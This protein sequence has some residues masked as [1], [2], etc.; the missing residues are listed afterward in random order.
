MTPSPVATGAAP[1]AAVDLPSDADAGLRLTA[2]LFEQLFKRRPTLLTMGAGGLTLFGRPGDRFAL[3]IPVKWGATVAAGSRDDGMVDLRS[4][5][6][7]GNELIRPVGALGDLPDWAVRPLAVVASAVAAGQP[8][9]GMSLLVGTALPESAG[10]QSDVALTSVLASA[11]AGLFGAELSL[12]RRAGLGDLPAQLAALSCPDDT[13]ML[14]DTREMTAEMV[15]FDLNGAG[16]RLMLIDLG[17]PVASVASGPAELALAAAD[18]LR[19]GNLM[20]LGPCSRRPPT[21]RPTR[22]GSR[23]QWRAPPPPPAPWASAPC[24]AGA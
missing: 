22:M 10:M 23:P 16:L 19:S 7:A 13:A 6:H 1:D 3:A 18:R 15:P 14:V 8:V 5:S 21:S 12:A 20:A 24:P 9:G 17:A 11:L 2:Y 4:G